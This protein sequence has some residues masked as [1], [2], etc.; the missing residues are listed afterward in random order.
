ME[1]LQI[2]LKLFNNIIISKNENP[3]CKIY[4]TMQE[5]LKD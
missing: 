1:E 4:Q 2:F 5:L 3:C